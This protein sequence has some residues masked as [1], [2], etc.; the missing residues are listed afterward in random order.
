MTTLRIKYVYEDMDRHGNVLRY[1][2]R[3]RG[4]KIRL[5]AV[6]G[7]DEFGREY[8]AAL[9]GKIEPRETE[10]LQGSRAKNGSLRWLIE[11]Y[12]ASAEF[13]RL[14]TSIKSARRG[15]LDNLCSEPVSDENSNLIGSLPYASMP[16]SKVRALRDRKAEFPEA[17]NGHIKAL[18]QVVKYAIA[19]EHPGAER[20][21]ARD[22]PYMKTG[23]QGFHTWTIAEVLQYAKKHP[24]GTKAH[25]A[26]ALLLF[27][28]QRR[29]DVVKF[30][31]QHIKNGWL[32]FTQV[33]NRKTKPVTLSIP[34]MPWLQSAIDA[35]PCGDLTFLVTEFGRPFT[36]NG[37]GNKVPRLVRPGRIKSLFG[38]WPGKGWRMRCGRER[39]GR[40]AADGDLRM[41]GDEGGRALYQE[42][43]P[44]TSR[45]ERDTAPVPRSNR[46]Q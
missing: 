42:G 15:I 32:T 27:T 44:T 3:N 38:T 23:S 22:V 45:R 28:G 13:T 17:A 46:E 5:R 35:S 26:L 29:S 2:Q 19:A 37:F 43:Q 14:D 4:P 11:Q 18:R 24:I 7:T 1:F 40:E 41:A 20:N 10:Q 25:L 31:R 9:N 8:Q 21:P 39:R 33:K 30:G 12:Y 16:S 36:G 6:P 34:I